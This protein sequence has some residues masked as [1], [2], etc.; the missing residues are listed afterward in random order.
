MWVFLSCRR[1]A[2]VPDGVS[3]FYSTAY[4]ARRIGHVAETRGPQVARV[5][6]DLSLASSW[7]R[8]P[9]S[10][11]REHGTWNMGPL[12]DLITLGPFSNPAAHHSQATSAPQRLRHPF[13]PPLILCQAVTE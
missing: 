2:L 6:P 4:R 9:G 13:I 1:G 12:H 8:P 10:D 7:K 5:L 3:G 11:L